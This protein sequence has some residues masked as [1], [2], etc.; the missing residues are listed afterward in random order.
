MS[1]YDITAGIENRIWAA[2]DKSISNNDK[3]TFRELLSFVR[4]VTSKSIAHDS[5]TVFKQYIFFFSNFYSLSFS[6]YKNNPSYLSLYTLCAEMAAL[7]L[8]EII[9]YEIKIFYKGS[10]VRGHEAEFYYWGFF[11]FNQL[12]FSMVNNHDT[13]QFEDA[14]GEFSQINLRSRD[15]GLDNKI[16]SLKSG[17]N[18]I[19][20]QAECVFQ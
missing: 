16:Q 9:L 15:F 7:H 13:V 10:S 14:L 5:L 17:E 1:N 11:G 18:T 6:K 20:D 2:I 8:K 4:N 12:L 19:K 3:A